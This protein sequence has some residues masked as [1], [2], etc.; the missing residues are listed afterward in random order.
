VAEAG[1]FAVDAPVAPGGVL[2]GRPQDELSE[3]G[4][5]GRPPRLGFGWLVPVAGDEPA[6]PSDHGCGL[7]DQENTAEPSPV[8]HI[9]EHREDRAVRVRELRTIDLALEYEDLVTQGKDFGVT[10]VAGREEPT[11][12]GENEACDGSEQE[13]GLRHGID[14]IRVAEHPQQHAD[15][16][17]ALSGTS[18]AAPNG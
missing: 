1:Q 8:E 10:A 11:E 17:P 9:G 14:R 6:V 4:V 5:D 15:E 2:G 7:H 16:F 12:P 18:G 13:H 3:F